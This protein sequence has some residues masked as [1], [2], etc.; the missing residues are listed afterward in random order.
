MHRQAPDLRP[1]RGPVSGQSCGPPGQY[2]P[3]KDVGGVRPRKRGPLLGQPI[4]G[5]PDRR[6]GR[7]RPTVPAPSGGL[8]SVGLCIKGPTNL[9]S[10]H[11]PVVSDS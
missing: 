10:P 11:H 3:G 5:A 2:A 9:R 4:R 7:G 6:A 8:G 1:A